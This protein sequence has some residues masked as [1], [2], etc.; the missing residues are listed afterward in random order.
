MSTSSVLTR[1]AQTADLPAS[2]RWAAAVTLDRA[3]TDL[4]FPTSVRQIVRVE[5]A[6]TYSVRVAH[7]NIGTWD[8]RVPESGWPY[9]L[10]HGGRR[11]DLGS[12][13]LRDRQSP[14]SIARDF[15]K[16]LRSQG[17]PG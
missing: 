11:H 5:E 16:F 6:D 7:S 13:W 10:H 8:L 2:E 12:D 1:P 17:F 9:E 14:I 15:A 4:G 3:L